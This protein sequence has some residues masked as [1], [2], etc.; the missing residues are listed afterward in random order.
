MV[1]VP[2]GHYDFCVSPTAGSRGRRVGAAKRFIFQRASFAGQC[3]ILGHDWYVSFGA[4]EFSTPAQTP[5]LPSAAPLSHDAF[6][7]AAPAVFI[8]ICQRLAGY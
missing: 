8:D 7:M 1:V 4:V 3:D 5:S 2:G 6:A